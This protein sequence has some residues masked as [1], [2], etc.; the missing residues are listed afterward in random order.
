LAAAVRVIHGV[1]GDA[2]HRRAYAAPPARAGLAELAQVVLAVPHLADRRA[3]FHVHAAGLARAQPQGHV[4]ALT[5]GD[6]RPAAGRAHELAALPG[7]HLDAVHRRAHRDVLQLERVARLDRRIVAGDDRRALLD[8]LRRQDV[9]P[10]AVRVLHERELPTPAPVGPEPLAHPRHAVLVAP[11]VHQPVALLVAAALVPRRDAPRVVAPALAV[12]LGQQRIQR[13]ALVQLGRLDGHREATA[14]GSRFRFLQCHVLLPYRPLLD[15]QE[16]DL[17][18][19]RHL[20]VGLL[21]GRALAVLE[22][23]A[24]HLAPAVHDRDVMDLDLEQ[25]LHRLA[26]FLLGR[27]PPHTEGDL[28]VRIGDDRAL[29]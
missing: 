24:L 21:P 8:V 11:E 12:L 28:V 23:M 14:R 17:A 10:L 15:A 7:L 26:D 16:I 2:A 3:A 5:R 4:G 27:V 29:L 1:H 25:E 19:G 22:G 6:L 13:L 9:A 18:A 20:H